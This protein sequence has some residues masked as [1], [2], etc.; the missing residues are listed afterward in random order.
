MADEAGTV[1]GDQLACERELATP[2]RLCHGSR[3]GMVLPGALE[4]ALTL[5]QLALGG[6]APPQEV[7]VRLPWI[8]GHKPYRAGEP[9]QQA[10]LAL[11]QVVTRRFHPCELES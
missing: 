11:R 7:R 8:L 9:A 5:G 3:L 10:L 1:A 4:D 2:D 6:G